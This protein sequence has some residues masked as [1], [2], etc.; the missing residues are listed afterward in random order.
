ME[1]AWRSRSA[2]RRSKSTP[3]ESR[4]LV[5]VEGEE[6]H[7][8][9]QAQGPALVGLGRCDG[10]NAQGPALR[11]ELQQALADRQGHLGRREH[12]RA[13]VDESAPHG[14][15]RRPRSRA[16]AESHVVMLPPLPSG[17]WKQTLW[18]VGAAGGRLE[19]PHVHPGRGHLT[20]QT[21][22]RFVLPDRAHG[23]DVKGIAGSARAEKHRRVVGD[24][25]ELAVVADVQ[26]TG[27][28]A[29]VP[30]EVV[31]PLEGEEDA[32]ADSPH[33][34]EYGD[35][36]PPARGAARSRSEEL[37]LR[38]LRDRMAGGLERGGERARPGA[39]AGA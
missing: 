11:A 8:G 17:Y 33:A 29:L 24:D 31:V 15:R 36:A 35:M 7:V 28:A 21:A 23:D 16:A 10:R 32:G 25:V 37:P 27:G 38:M 4:R 14:R 3:V 5:L 9:E 13:S 30:A 1:Q 34:H 22:S 2:S 39:V 12:D 19:E 6:V 18:S 26:E 20:P